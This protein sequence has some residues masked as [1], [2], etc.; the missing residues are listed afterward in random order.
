MT[1][2]S[3]IDC[4]LKYKQETQLITTE[5]A[6]KIIAKSNF[7]L[8]Q[9][10]TT[11]FLFSKSHEEKSK[12]IKQMSLKFVKF[13]KKEGNS[14]KRKNSTI[15]NNSNKTRKREQNKSLSIYLYNIVKSQLSGS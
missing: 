8:Y 7:R 11:G 10:K 14:R 9:E 4:F 6:K 3:N 12:N 15:N 1:N 2:V 13:L 5:I